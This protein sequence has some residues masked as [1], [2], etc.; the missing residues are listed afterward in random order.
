MSYKNGEIYGAVSIRDVQRAIGSSSADLGTLIRNGNINKWARYKP[1]AY[2]GVSKIRSRDIRTY[3]L[4]FTP[5][6]VFDAKTGLNVGLMTG[7]PSDVAGWT[8]VEIAYERPSGGTAQ[9]FRLTDWSGYNHYAQKPARFIWKNTFKKDQ[10]M[11]CTVSIYD[12]STAGEDGYITFND[13]ISDPSFA[14]SAEKRLCMAVYDMTVSDTEPSFYF[15]SEKFT[16]IGSMGTM[17]VSCT[18]RNSSFAQWLVEGRRYKFLTMMVTNHSY[19]EQIVSGNIERWE[20]GISATEMA[21]IETGTGAIKALCLA[22]ELGEDR[23]ERVLQQASI[24]TDVAYSLDVLEVA[25]YGNIVYVSNYAKLC[26]ILNLP[27]IVVRTLQQLNGSAQYQFRVSFSQGSGSETTIFRPT[28]KSGND[29]YAIQSYPSATLP[30]TVLT[31]WVSVSDIGTAGYSTETDAQGRTVHV[32]EFDFYNRTYTITSN[33]DS[34]T[35]GRSGLFLFFD[36]QDNFQ[37]TFS[38]YYRD[39]STANEVLIKTITVQYYIAD[40]S[41]H[42]YDMEW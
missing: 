9:P 4:P 13:L 39:S 34:Q 6:P 25:K 14:Q 26:T 36:Q 15:F 35:L 18:L 7:T 24:I 16:T 31:P 33:S 22:F 37:L 20:Y 5:D 30:E 40:G 19:L 17:S 32:Y 41:G 12:R 2:A 11:S 10:M 29:Y 27:A 42:V 8:D 23:C 38:L 3:G 1:V 28:D 21:S